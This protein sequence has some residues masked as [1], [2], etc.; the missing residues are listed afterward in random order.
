MRTAVDLLP[1]LCSFWALSEHFLG[2]YSRHVN[3]YQV[4]QLDGEAWKQ[5]VN[6]KN[7]KSIPELILRNTANSLSSQSMK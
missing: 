3:Q 1:S 2:T 5:R 4:S 6:M 7:N